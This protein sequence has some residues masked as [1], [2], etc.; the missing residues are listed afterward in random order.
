M[1]KK[2][3][4]FFI[5]FSCCHLLFSQ[6][7]DTI[8]YNKYWNK[9]TKETAHFFRPM[10]L[11]KQ[12]NLYLIKDY[13]GNGNIQMKAFSSKEKEDVFEG[14]TTWYYEKGGVKTERHYENGKIVGPE[15]SYFINGNLRSLGTYK[16][17]TFFK[18]DFYTSDASEYKTM[19]YKEGKLVSKN[20]YYENSKKVASKILYTQNFV[21]DKTVYFDE[22]GDILAI[23]D[24][25]NPSKLTKVYSSLSKNNNTKEVVFLIYEEEKDFK[26]EQV[27]KD[28]NQTI[29][30]KGI[31]ENG[32]PYE[33]KFLK[34]YKLI[35]YKEGIKDGEVISYNKKFEKVAKG[36]YNDGQQFS[37]K[38]HELYSEEIKTLEK[39]KVVAKQTKNKFTG[40]VYNCVFDNYTPIEGDYQTSNRLESYSNKRITK[41]I[42]FNYNTGE[43]QSVTL[44]DKT[45]YG[46]TKMIYYFNNQENIVTYKNGLPYEGKEIT[47][48]GFI[49]HTEGKITG[50]FLKKEGIIN[51]IGNYKDYKKNGKILFVSRK[52]NDTIACIFE[53]DMP[54]E[55]IE[56]DYGNKT[57]YKD[58]KKHGCSFKVFN[59]RKYA[60]DSLHICYKNGMPIDTAKYYKKKKL[61]ANTI[62]KKGKP[63]EGTF[64]KQTNKTVFKNG[65]IKENEIV[66]SNDFSQQKFFDV[67]G[68]YIKE[69]VKEIDKDSVMYEASYK[70]GL[71]YIGTILSY[72]SI[73]K[74]HVETPYLK[75]KKEG[76]QKFYKNLSKPF[77]K[78][79]TYKRDRKDG[80]AKF[81][82]RFSDTIYEVF[83]R[84][85]KPYHG[86]LIKENKYDIAKKSFK[87]GK[88]QAITYY[89]TYSG[90]ILSS[91][92][93]K[94]GKPYD[95]LL[96]ETNKEGEENLKRY[97]G[98]NLMITY[99][100]TSKYFELDEPKYFKFKI[101]HSKLKDSVVK[102]G[103]YTDKSSYF[104]IFYDTAKKESGSVNYYIND[105]LKGKS[106][107]KK[108]KLLTFNYKENNFNNF[109]I[110]INLLE[111]S[112][113]Y[114]L[115]SG[116]YRAVFKTVNKVIDTSYYEFFSKIINI[117]SN[118]NIEVTLYLGSN[119]PVSKVTVKDNKPY[120]GMIFIP[121]DDL[122]SLRVFKN[123]TRS[124]NFKL[125]TKQ[126]LL[127]KIE[128]L[129]AE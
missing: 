63:F 47:G 29:I 127:D 70:N 71:P 4:I 53:D 31:L 116:E 25:R 122:F 118:I 41:R 58:G 95:G 43:K 107:F 22:I 82:T 3:I 73:H 34:N 89:D 44:Y 9:S 52:S 15:K 32:R 38:F 11:E 45:T 24:H 72:D 77:I 21:Q 104:N 5:L 78:Q 93:Y 16:N 91:L 74:L 65:K 97:K 103:L 114:E 27:V 112:L 81:G 87:D 69:I 125:L 1:Y 2:H 101:H 12:H 23:I 123:G 66:I 120:N 18:G 64:Y 6:L 88:V 83:Y 80:V 14:K 94:K 36:I 10:P 28:K 67:N 7:K 124:G 109:K 37:G 59:Y 84:K 17:G 113:N 121:T 90:K 115:T 99:I 8:Y 128:A 79:Y 56:L 106:I 110:H 129:K 40:E 55:G 85:G 42:N 75:G 119:I 105:S 61:I 49:T 50:P 39:G 68:E 86:E 96:K 54:I 92:K 19:T 48:D 111:D 51:V 60:Y 33:G 57:S 30:A 126:Q 108:N 20:S 35:N 98:G 26:V 100:G 62:Y 46:I 13:Y 102:K 76:I 117:E